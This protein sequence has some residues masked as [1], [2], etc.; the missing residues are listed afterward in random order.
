MDNIIIGDQ[1]KLDPRGQDVCKELWEGFGFS[2]GTVGE[3]TDIQNIHGAPVATVVVRENKNLFPLLCLIK[4][5]QV[6][7]GKK[8]RKVKSKRKSKRKSR[9]RSKRRKSK[10]NKSKKK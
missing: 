4:H 7:S 6:G 10:R 3:V 5:N 2:A 1:V 9:R 8:N